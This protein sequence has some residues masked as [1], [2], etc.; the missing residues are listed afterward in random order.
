MDKDY[1]KLYRSYNDY[2]QERFSCRVYKVCIDGGFTCPN[3]DGTKGF[4]GC[5]FCDETGS[6]SRTHTASIP[7]EEQIKKNILIRKTRFK[8]KKFIVYFQSYSNTYASPEHLKKIYDRAVCAH[9]DIIGLSIATRPDCIDEEKIALIANYKKR[10]P[11]V[12]IEYGLQT[13]HNR[14]LEKINRRETFEDFEKA[15]ALT[16]N[17][18]LDHCIHVI[19]GLPEESR[20]E[21]LAT[22]EALAKMNIRAIKI[23]LLIAMENTFLADRYFLGEWSPMSF[24]EYISLVCDFIERLPPKCTIHRLAGNG[25]PLH[26]VAPKWVY[27]KKTCAIKAIKEELVKRN[28]YQGFLYNKNK[29]LFS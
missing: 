25:H 14:T 20:K 29:S 24:H 22:A 2:M 23:H 9:P 16:Q 18:Q 10:F 3:R 11:Y 12:S 7:I 13:I 8:A 1:K 15:F 5:I 27:Q 28:T 19:L 17:Y 4:G 21:Q 26:L 6:S